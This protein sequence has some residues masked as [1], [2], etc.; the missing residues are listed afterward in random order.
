MKQPCNSL[1]PSP[2]LMTLQVDYAANPSI[3]RVYHLCK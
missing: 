3:R 1:P 2:S